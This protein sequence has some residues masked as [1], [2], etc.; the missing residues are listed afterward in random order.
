MLTE[1]VLGC[2][3]RWSRWDTKGFRFF[4]WCWTLRHIIREIRGTASAPGTGSKGEK[5]RGLERD[6]FSTLL[7]RN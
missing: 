7:G 3:G 4:D 1:Y 2:R 6:S 5:E